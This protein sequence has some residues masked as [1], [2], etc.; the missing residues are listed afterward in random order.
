[1]P[2]YA[3][4]GLT[5]RNLAATERFYTQYFGFRRARVVD[6]GGGKQIIFLKGSGTYLE[7]FQ[8]EGC[9]PAGAPSADGHGFPGIRHLAFDV[10]DV[11]AFAKTLGADLKVNLGPLH[12]DAFIPGWAAVWV[13]DPDDRVVEICQGY[14]DDNNPPPFAG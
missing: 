12:F 4:T 14:R 2:R 9:D 11:D 13:R 7:L 1:M 5:C 6:L 10:D 3:H 8:G